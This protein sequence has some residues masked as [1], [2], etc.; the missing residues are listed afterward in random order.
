MQKF[1]GAVTPLPDDTRVTYLAG[2]RILNEAPLIPFSDL[3][4]EFLG[5][6]SKKLRS[7]TRSAQYPDLLA[8]AFWCRKSH[9]TKL[10]ALYQTDKPRIGLGLTFHIAPSNVPI[11]FAYSFAF[12]VLA[13]N[14]NLVRLP[15]RQFR[16][17]DVFCEVVRNLFVEPDF[18]LL[19]SMNTFVRYPAEED[20]TKQFSAQV[21]ARVI[22]GGD[23]TIDLIR[24]HP[25]K[26]GGVEISFRD[27]A[28]ICVIESRAVDSLGP[29]DLEHLARKFYADSYT[30]DQNACSSPSLVI[31]VGKCT[32]E[33]KRENFWDAVARIARRRY[34][35]E[36]IQAVDKYMTLCRDAILIPG[37]KIRR[38]GGILYRVETPLLMPRLEDH[39]RR[40][41]YFIE[42]KAEDLN[43]IV[44]LL[45]S[46]CQTLTYFG[47]PRE[48]VLKLVLD[49]HLTGVDRIVPIGSALNMD[50]I[51]DGFDIIRFLSRVIDIH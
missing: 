1:E 3:A 28:S 34:S 39:R 33:Q 45:E 10:K 25:I 18:S 37:V 12:G 24:R 26:P 21:R 11:T 6:L 13:G 44:P 15:S 23:E 7:D 41:G 40:F 29:E 22:W 30:L 35:L 42:Y 46:K 51:W 20:L 48:V 31:W 27:R 49:H 5:L 2:G 38:H 32:G 47:I 4:C 8:F 43:Q 9:I 36:P 16:Q 17:I 19:A 50:L 14:A